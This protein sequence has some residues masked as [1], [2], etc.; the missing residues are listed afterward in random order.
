MYFFIQNSDDEII[1][2]VEIKHDEPPLW[3]LKSMYSDTRIYS[4]HFTKNITY[5]IWFITRQIMR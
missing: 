1:R 5:T 3:Y 2:Q 4:G